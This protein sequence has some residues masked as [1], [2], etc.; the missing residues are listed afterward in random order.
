MRKSIK[1]A[2]ILWQRVLEMF[3]FVKVSIHLKA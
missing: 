2:L 3:Y 1:E